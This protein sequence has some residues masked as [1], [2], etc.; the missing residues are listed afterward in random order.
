MRITAADIDAPK[1]DR[2]ESMLSENEE[3]FMYFG[4]ALTRLLHYDFEA[5]FYFC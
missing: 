3:R 4:S 5:L 1:K 2:D